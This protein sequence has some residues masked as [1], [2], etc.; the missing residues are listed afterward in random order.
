MFY[1]LVLA[2]CNFLCG[3]YSCQTLHES[4]VIDHRVKMVDCGSAPKPRE[5]R[6]PSNVVVCPE[7]CAY[8]GGRAFSF[9]GGWPFGLDPN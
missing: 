6:M 4:Q 9:F 8:S 3:S 7:S 1:T 5:N 2:C